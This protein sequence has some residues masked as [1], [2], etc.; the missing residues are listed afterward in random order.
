M[1][2][3]IPEAATAAVHQVMAI[4][5]TSAEFKKDFNLVVKGEDFMQEISLDALMSKMITTGFQATNVGHAIN[6]INRM[7]ALR[8]QDRPG[9]VARTD[10]PE[11]KF[12]TIFLSYTSNMISSG[13][14]ETIRFLVQHKLVDV[15][16][17]TAGGIEEDFMK[18]LADTYVGDFKLNGKELRLKG[19]NRLGNLIIPN[20]NYCLF[21]DFLNPILDTISN[22]QVNEGT[23]WTPCKLIERLGKEINNEQSVYYWAHKN[24]IPVFC[25]GITDG[26][27]GDML[28]FHNYKRP[29][30]SL[31]L[32]EDIRRL[33]D[34]AVRA[35]CTGM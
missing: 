21:E 30:F 25:P 17:T 5:T 32:V 8:V 19:I 18:C 26:S 23:R 13:L 34:I 15:L 4:S 29:E 11:L 9:Y 33:N 7:I 22:E 3:Q 10:I 2:E 31:D 27:L 12:C 16:I 20:Q 24:G 1:A 28:Y 6:E 14:R 35:S